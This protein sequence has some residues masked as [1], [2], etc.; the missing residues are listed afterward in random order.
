[1]AHVFLMAGEERIELS[2]T[3]LE[4]AV[5]PLNYSPKEARN[6]LIFL[7]FLVNAFSK[8]EVYLPW[9]SLAMRLTRPMSALPLYSVLNLTMMA[10]TD[11]S[12]ISSMTLRISSSLISSGR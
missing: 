11:L 7:P 6:S 2:I 3:V 8:S 1:M 5:M 4:T 12:G 9:N 10:L